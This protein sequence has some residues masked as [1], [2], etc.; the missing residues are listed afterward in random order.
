MWSFLPSPPDFSREQDPQVPASPEPQGMSVFCCHV[1]VIPQCSFL[2][3]SA[4]G[5]RYPPSIAAVNTTPGTVKGGPPLTY[6][7]WCRSSQ[8]SHDSLSQPVARV[9]GSGGIARRSK[10]LLYTRLASVCRKIWAGSVRGR[11]ALVSA[12]PARRR[13]HRR[14]VSVQSKCGDPPAACTAARN[15]LKW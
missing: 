13:P 1:A 2:P 3:V 9:T 12:L 7:E 8:R 10:G 4:D 5:V 6:A 15:P 11:R 14:G